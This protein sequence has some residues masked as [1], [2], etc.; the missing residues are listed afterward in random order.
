MTSLF[1]LQSLSRFF[2]DSIPDISDVPVVWALSAVVLFI[3]ATI[4]AYKDLKSSGIFSTESPQTNRRGIFQ[5][6]TEGLELPWAGVFVS[7]LTGLLTLLALAY[8]DLVYKE[9]D[10]IDTNG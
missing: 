6:A 10:F 4:Q 8:H 7:L 2:K 3:S 9:M 5:R 1:M